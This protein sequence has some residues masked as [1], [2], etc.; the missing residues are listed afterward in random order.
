MFVNNQYN[1]STT[2]TSGYPTAPYQNLSGLSNNLLGA[3]TTSTSTVSPA[4]TS[5]TNPLAANQAQAAAALQYTNP[6]TGTGY[7]QVAQLSGVS[8][9]SPT[10]PS[11]VSSSLLN[12][13]YGTGSTSPASALSQQYANSLALQ[14]SQFAT[15]Q[16]ATNMVNAQMQQQAN[17]A[18]ANQAMVIGNQIQVDARK[19]AQDVNDMNHAEAT[20]EF[21]TIQQVGM[22][23]DQATHKGTQSWTKYIEG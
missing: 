9:Y 18:D 8:G 16:Q 20:N 14:Q 13:Q 3:P 12:Q 6:T 17:N 10:S 2:T 21:S 19:N 23:Q 22:N 4:N 1:K 11:S 5:Y 15:Q 7:P